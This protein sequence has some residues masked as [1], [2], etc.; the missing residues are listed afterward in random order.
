MFCLC[1][2]LNLLEKTKSLKKKNFF[3]I[4]IVLSTHLFFLVGI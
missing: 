2:S 3:G 1:S 4:I